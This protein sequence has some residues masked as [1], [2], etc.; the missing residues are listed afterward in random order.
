MSKTLCAIESEMWKI[1]YVC[2][3]ILN[4]SYGRIAQLVR[5]P[6]LYLGGSGF[7]SLCAHKN[8]KCVSLP[9]RFAYIFRVTIGSL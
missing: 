8:I 3:T 1:Y 2:S 5:A 6:S 9:F 7:E 4:V